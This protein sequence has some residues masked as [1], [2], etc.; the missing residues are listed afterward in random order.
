MKLA[1]FITASMFALVS[2]A[3]AD[4]LVLRNG[5][6]LTGTYRG[7]T[8]TEIW[9]QQP[10][11]APTVIS[12]STIETLTFGPA[13]GGLPIFPGSALRKS[14]GK[15]VRAIPA[16]IGGRSVREKKAV[17]PERKKPAVVPSGETSL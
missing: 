10:G 6:T 3:S 13:S 16:A 12:T 7:G 17:L 11:A 1:A 9:F 15:Q 14:P 8:N 2:A 5:V 4:T